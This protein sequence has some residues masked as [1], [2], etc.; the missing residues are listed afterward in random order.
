MKNRI[1]NS[2]TILG[3]SIIMYAILAVLMYTEILDEYNGQ[4]LTLAGIYVIISLS[5]NLMTG[6]TGQLVLGQA[7]FMC[8]GAYSS[9]IAIMTF[10]VPLFFAIIIGGVITALFGFLIG[11]PALRLRGDY[12]AITTLG[13]GE[14]VRVVM[15]NL[16]SLTGGAAGL[17]GVPSFSNTGNFITDDIIKFTWVFGFVV[18]SLLIITNLMRSSHGRAIIS[19]REDEIAA[20]SMGVD[21]AY[22]KIFS[23]TIAAFI[24]GLGGGLY[25]AYFGYLNPV[26]FGFMNSANFVVIVVLG[27]L[28]SVTGTII[29]AI[30]FT[31]AQE[32]MRVFQDFR[33]VIFGLALILVMLFWQKGIMG[34]KEF[35]I[36]GFARDLLAGRYSIKRI[37]SKISKLIKKWKEKKQP[38]DRG[39]K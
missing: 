22:Y 10:H 37:I 13:F 14:I 16:K 24:A 1:F 2:I 4:L 36:V 21:T 30:G 6:F 34:S 32:W 3:A 31:Y 35:S 29:A 23:F 9:A 15:V 25:A 28:G 18:I 26:M 7:G 8:I 5:L 38:D 33:M 17:K 12:L 27:G 39:V 19:I 11:F 20:N